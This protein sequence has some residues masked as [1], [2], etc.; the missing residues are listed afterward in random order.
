MTLEEQYPIGTVVATKIADSYYFVIGYSKK[1]DK[2]R[3]TSRW[4]SSST[5]STV[6]YV[7]ESEPFYSTYNK[8]WLDEVSQKMG[9]PLIYKLQVI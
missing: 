5:V 6:R 3:V 4:N 7:Y 8:R 1:G 2:L 9:I